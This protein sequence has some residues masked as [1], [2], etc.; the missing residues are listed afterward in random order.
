MAKFDELFPLIVETDGATSRITG[1]SGYTFYTF[2][3]DRFESVG[4]RSGWQRHLTPDEL[5]Q[6]VLTSI[7]I[8]QMTIR[9]QQPVK[10]V[11]PGLRFLPEGV[12]EMA[13]EKTREM[14][15]ALGEVQRRRDEGTLLPAHRDVPQPPAAE[16]WA[17]AEDSDGLD[18]LVVDADWLARSPVQRVSERLTEAV[19]AALAS[20]A[21]CV[22]TVVD[23]AVQRLQQLANEA[24]MIMGESR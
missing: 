9:S 24:E 23:P 18:E 13:W 14:L 5:T 7:Q 2:V 1:M 6:E 12:S 16:V 19:V 17:R 21:P 4:V 10:S 8:T 3:D 20:P 11:A 22:E 15:D